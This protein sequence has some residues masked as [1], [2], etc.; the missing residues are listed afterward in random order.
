MSG[1]KQIT[2]IG[3][4]N[5]AHHLGKAF[6]SAGIKI[7]C[8]YSRNIENA[9]SLAE[10]LES[11][12]VDQINNLPSYSDLYLFAVNDSSI[13]YLAKQLSDCCGYNL[14]VVH[15]SG[16][17][18]VDVF[19]EHFNTYGSFY[20]LQTF[21]K[22]RS[23]N[24]REVPFFI[25]S[26]ESG[27]ENKLYDLATSIADSAK[28]VSDSDRKAL[29]VSAVFANNFTNYLYSISKDILLK[30][31]LDFELIFPLIKETTRKIL[32]GENPSDIQTG[33]AIRKDEKTINDH[34]D[35]LKKFPE[36]K[37]LYTLMTKS[38]QQELTDKLK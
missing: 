8:V 7:D 20:P 29:H 10:E 13:G 18:S 23:L 22:D 26:N 27:F 11:F 5:V 38:I 36:Y 4:G 25:T 3:S 32:S 6:K 28:L 30:E 31:N 9:E 24:I 37:K 15:T 33:P 34:L 14:N 2:L 17:E 1:I 21:T 35:Y 12:A 19:K 16:M